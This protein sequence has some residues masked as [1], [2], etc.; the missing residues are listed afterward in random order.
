MSVLYL[1]GCTLKNKASN[2]DRS[3]VAAMDRLGIEL[4]EL[5]RWNCCGTVFSMAGD[6]LMQQ[7]AP[8]RNLL[9]AEQQGDG[10]LLVPCSMCYNTLERARRF[11]GQDPERVRKVNDFMYREDCGYQGKVRVLHPLA[12]LRDELGWER[13]RE[14]V[15]RP[16][17]GVKMAAYYGCLLTRPADVAI[18][19][20]ENPRVFEDLLEALGAEPAAFALRDECCGSYQTLTNRAGTLRRAHEILGAAARSGAEALVTSCPLCAYNLD[21]M[22]REAAKQYDLNSMPVFYFSELMA[23][24]LGVEW[25][26]DWT[27]LHEVNPEAMLEAI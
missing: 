26:S 21:Q 6:D 5:E 15:S 19:D 3:F 17:A 23:L 4:A 24:A 13:V 27:G 9:R 11:A 25:D 16:L 22:Q 14:R 12:F 1:P 7:L 10:P 18:D 2:F 8:L 20:S